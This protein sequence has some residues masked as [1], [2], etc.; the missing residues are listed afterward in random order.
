MVNAPLLEK[1]RRKLETPRAA[2]IAG[3]LFALLY[4]GSLVLIRLSIPTDL[5]VESSA[6]LDANINTISLALNMI[7]YAGIAFPWQIS[8]LHT[9]PTEVYATD[10][11]VFTATDPLSCRVDHT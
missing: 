9:F 1:T 5:T 10:A 8:P 3:I 6:W 4:G 11:T 7:P 2:A